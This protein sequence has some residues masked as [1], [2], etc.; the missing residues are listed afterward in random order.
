[1]DVKTL[2]C[3]FE[4]ESAPFCGFV[5]E[6]LPELEWI[7]LRGADLANI[8]QYGVLLG[9]SVD[10]TLGSPKGSLIISPTHSLTRDHPF[11]TARVSNFS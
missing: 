7:R 6:R 2:D 5:N 9:P 8:D 10:H 1:M 11:S 3:T 4:N